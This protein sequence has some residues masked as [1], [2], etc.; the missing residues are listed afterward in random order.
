M[1]PEVNNLVSLFQKILQTYTVIEKNPIVIPTGQIIHLTEVQT[2]AAIGDHPGINMTQLAEVIGVTRG[3]VS[4][5]LRKL[6]HKKLVHR[7][8]QK[9][10]KEINLSLTQIGEV[11]Q[12]SYHEKMKEIFLFAESL[13]E[14]A[15]NAER[16]LARRLFQAIHQNLLERINGSNEE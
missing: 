8:K 15:T 9:N 4:Q 10:N 2:I 16:D 1:N 14:S 13:Y 12:V 11:V 3:A 7:S 6:T 5:T